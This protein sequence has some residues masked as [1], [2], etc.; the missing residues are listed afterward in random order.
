M[1]DIL[2]N[3]VVKS[4]E[5]EEE[6]EKKESHDVDI[7]DTRR[8]SS[9]SRFFSCKLLRNVTIEFVVKVNTILQWTLLSTLLLFIV[10]YGSLAAGYY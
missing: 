6:N 7:S 4:K 10:I 5:E 2:H 3:R 1:V 8:R 9:I